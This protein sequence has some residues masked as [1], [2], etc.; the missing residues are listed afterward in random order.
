MQ[1][2]AFVSAE[3]GAGLLGD[4]Y[5]TAA[6]YWRDL[7]VSRDLTLVEAE[8]IEALAT[9][10][11]IALAPGET[12]RNLT[13]RGI[14]LND[15]V[16]RT[17]WVGDV[18]ARGTSLCEPCRHLE[19]VTGKHLLR[20]LVHRGGLRA[21]LLSSGTIRVDDAVTPAE[22]Q[23]GVGVLVVRDQQ[24]LLGRRLGAHGH[25]GHFPAAS[26]PRESQY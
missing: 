13:T 18:L 26:R 10:S 16:G 19:E 22:K 11:G 20:P 24:I 12:R 7:R 25:G 23:Q 1:A 3:A 6:G 2:R 21:D 17:F 9:S 15:L 4:R 14:S 8:V 5:A